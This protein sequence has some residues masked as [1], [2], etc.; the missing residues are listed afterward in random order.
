MA[1]KGPEYAVK[2]RIKQQLT[3]LGADCWWYMPVAGPFSIA[4]VPDFVGIYKGKGFGIEAK[5]ENGKVTAH[6]K[7]Q[8][9]MIAAAKGFSIIV[10][11]VED[12]GLVAE[13]LR[14]A[15]L[16]WETVKETP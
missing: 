11:G 16:K 3:S 13:Q 5:A 7:R 6:Q 9:G 1:T 15:W 2:L 8:L 12:A 14:A 10:R 4:G